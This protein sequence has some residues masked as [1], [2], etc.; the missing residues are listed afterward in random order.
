MMCDLSSSMRRFSLC[1]R[2]LVLAGACRW[3]ARTPM[4]C[5]AGHGRPVLSLL[6]RWP[7]LDAKVVSELIFT[8]DLCSGIAP[9]NSFAAALPT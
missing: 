7:H 3:L 8:D 2:S 5:S 6:A 4:A 9:W 1:G